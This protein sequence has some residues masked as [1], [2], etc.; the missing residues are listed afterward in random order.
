[1]WFYSSTRFQRSESYI[2]GLWENKNAGD[3]TKWL[4]EADLDNQTSSFLKSNTV[5]SRVTW[6]ASPRNKFNVYF[7]NSWRYWNASLVGV[8]SESEQKYDFPRLWQVTG[9]WSSPV[10][11][12]M[13]IDVR[14]GMHKEDIF[15][16]YDRGPER[17]RTA[18]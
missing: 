11:N 6:Q 17:R 12:K 3:L 2:A 7:D 13:L 15:N 10:S 4:Y 5:N 16:F 9:G 1:M 8:S 14:G 18:I